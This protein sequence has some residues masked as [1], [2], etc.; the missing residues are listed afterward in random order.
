MDQ[1]IA[2]I[3]NAFV[4]LK[5]N[6]TMLVPGGIAG[7]VLTHWINRR[8]NRLQSFDYTVHHERIGVTDN[9]G[10]GDIKVTFNGNVV[11]NLYLTTITLTN[12]TTK[13]QLGV[14]FRVNAGTSTVLMTQFVGIKGTTYIFPFSDE[15]QKQL[16]FDDKPNQHQVTLYS[17]QREFTISTFNKGAVAEVRLLTNVPS[18]NGGPTTFVDMLRAN[19]KVRYVESGPMMMGIPLTKSRVVGLMVVLSLF[20]VCGFISGTWISSFVALCAGLCVAP[21]GAIAYRLWRGFLAAMPG[22]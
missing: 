17:Q 21:I 20:L 11:P 13:D 4:W 14:T 1:L 12:T 15:Y 8:A 19:T 2:E 3:A 7:A 5:A 10:F 22:Y 6:W 18:G 16:S 9:G